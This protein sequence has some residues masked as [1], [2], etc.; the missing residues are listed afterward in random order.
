MKLIFLDIDGVLVTRR[1]GVFEEG[2]LRNLQSLAQKTECDIV[3]STDW[4]RHPSARD[5][6]RSVL[7]SLGLRVIGCTPR[8][9]PFV[10]QRPTE[11]L[12]WKRDF[13]KRPGIEPV[14]H[15]IAIDDRALL[16]ERHG[17]YLRGHFLQTHPL[18]GLTEERV[19]EGM[20]LLSLAPA[21]AE[22]KGGFVAEGSPLEAAGPR[23]GTSTRRG[24]ST[25]A[26]PH[27]TS[28]APSPS[29][30]QA[31][32][33]ARAKSAS[34]HARPMGLAPGGPSS[35]RKAASAATSPLEALLPALPSAS[36]GAGGLTAGASMVGRSAEPPGGSGLAG[37][38]GRGPASGRPGR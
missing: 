19:E 7:A 4:R 36:G 28:S 37:P 9:S 35:G 27:G 3:L 8:L 29:V 18:R 30:A 24:L 1:P 34:S 13:C 2:L 38:R 10:P 17:Q 6:A 15:W 14:T 25:G 26:R 5:E 16:E 12:Q 11:I 20:R 22:E 31:L 32:A 33:A 21:P 23:G